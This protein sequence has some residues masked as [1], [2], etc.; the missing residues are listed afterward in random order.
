ML[1]YK[2]TTIYLAH[3]P[4]RKEKPAIFLMLL[5][6]RALVRAL[7]TRK[8]MRSKDAQCKTEEWPSKQITAHKCFVRIFIHSYKNFAELTLSPSSLFPSNILQ[9]VRTPKGPF[10]GPRFRS[11]KGPRSRALS[12]PLNSAPGSVETVFG[13]PHSTTQHVRTPSS[14][15]MGFQASQQNLRAPV[16]PLPSHLAPRFCC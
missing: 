3:E 6:V 11:P 1:V 9:L 10:S 5:N 12:L 15:T 16:L 8:F 2:K 14:N 4:S 7:I 13:A